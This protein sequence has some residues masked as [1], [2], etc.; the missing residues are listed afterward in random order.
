M[1][2]LSQLL[3]MLKDDPDDVFLHYAVACE[4]S[5]AGDRAASFADFQVLHERFP[6]YVPAWFRHAQLLAE[7]GLSTEARRIGTIGLQTAQRVGD[8]HAAGEL[9]QFLELL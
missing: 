3:E 5:K 1:N 6:D 8:H 7:D 4:R 9:E 2:R